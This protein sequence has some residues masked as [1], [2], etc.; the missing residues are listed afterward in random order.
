M[1][2]LASHV[3]LKSPKTEFPTTHIHGRP[4]LQALCSNNI[5]FYDNYNV[6]Y[7]YY[8]LASLLTFT[9]TIRSGSYK[10]K[11]VYIYRYKP[12]FAPGT[13]YKSSRLLLLASYT[14]PESALA[15]IR[16]YYKFYTA[17]YDAFDIR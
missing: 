14:S 16:S 11:V 5:Y 6:V 3:W 4:H 15:S 9:P 12:S 8:K 1:R 13:F 2:L 10:T 17:D 7:N